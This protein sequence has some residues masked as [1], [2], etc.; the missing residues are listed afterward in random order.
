MPQKTNLNINPYYDDFDADKN[1]Y[2]VL[3]KPGFPVQARELTTLQSIFQNQIE[4]FGSHIF[5]E[6]SMVIPGSISYDSSYYSVKINSTHLGLDVTLYLDKLINKRIQGQNSGVT[7]EIK[8]YSLPPNDG[9]ED[10]TLYVK[11]ISTG[12]DFQTGIFEDGEVLITLDNIVYGNT[13]IATGET[14][15]SLVDVNATATGSAVNLTSGV[16]FLRG[17]FIDV[18]D[19]TLVLDPYSNAP[20]YRVGL[21]ISEEIIT[22]DDDSSLNDNARGFSNF[23]A[24]GAD[25]LKISTRLSKKLLTDFDDKSFV[26]LLRVDLGEIKKLQDKSVYS[27][28]K[29][30]FAQR[31]YDESGD[32]TVSP[33]DVDILNSL[34]DNLGNNGVYQETQKTDQGATP[35]DDLMIVRV[36]P[37]KAYVRG[38]DISLPGNTNI[39]VPKPRDT[40]EVPTALIPFELGSR[41]TVNNVRGTP[42]VGLNT[43]GNKVTLF[44]TRKSS[45]GVGETTVG[46]ARVYSFGLTDS[47]YNDASTK[48][49]LYLFDVQTYTRL[50]LNEVLTTSEAPKGSFIKGLSSGASGFTVADAATSTNITLSNTS[51]TFIRGEQ[52]SIN[53]TQIVSRS[54]KDITA[55]SINDIKSVYQTPQALNNALKT[56]FSADCVLY[57]KLAPDF[58]VTDAISIGGASGICTSAGKSFLGISTNSIVTYQKPDLTIPTYN[59]VVSVSPSGNSMTLGAVPSITNILDGTLPTTQINGIKFSLGVPNIK[60]S[61]NGAFY[62]PL[63]FKDVSSVNLSNA[64]LVVSTQ[65]TEQTTDSNGTMTIIT[66]NTGISSAF[67]EPFDPEKYSIFYS[68]GTIEDLTSDQLTISN[69][70]ARL[71]ITGLR[72]N[73]SGANSITVNVTLRKYNV[74]N[75]SK[76]YT[77]SQQLSVNK[78][79]SGIQTSITGL[80]SSQ[81]YGLRVEDQEISLNVPDV[82]KVIAIYESLNTSAPVLDKM[83]F[84]AGLSLDTQSVV[85]E[86]LI[87]KTSRAIGQI[88]NRIAGG[89]TIEHVTLSKNQFI[90]G[91][92]ILFEE[93]RISSTLLDYQPGSYLNIT[94]NY[95]LDKNQKIQYYDYSKIVRIPSAPA[96]T[97]QLLVIFD[98][99]KVPDADA[100]D[101][102]TVNS[103]DNERFLSDIPNLSNGV[104]A[105]DT[106]DF[107][108]RVPEFTSTNRSPF[109]FEDKGFSLYTSKAIITPNEGSLISYSHYLPRRDKVVLNKLGELSVI[110]GIS[111]LNPSTPVNVEDAMDIATI[112]LPAYLYSPDDAKI[113]FVDNRRYTMRDIGKLED[114]IENLEITTSLSLLELN[115]KTLQ[116][117]DADGLGRFKTGFFADDFKDDKFIDLEDPD[118]SCAVNTSEQTLI[119]KVD[120][121]SLGLQL[122]LDP[123]INTDTADF[124]ENLTLLD[125]NVQKTGDLITLK[126][127]QKEWIK[128]AFASRVENVN[129]FNI[130]EYSGAV[131]LNPNTDNWVR[132]IYIAKNRTVIAGGREFTYVED[133]KVSSEPDPFMR[134]RNVEFSAGGLRPLTRHYHFL[135]SITDLSIIPKLVEIEMKSG[136]F[137][138]GETISGISAIVK[139]FE[140]LKCRLAQPN[141][142]SGPYNSPTKTY[143]I[144][145]YNSSET[146]P[147]A[148]SKSSTVLNVD[149]KSLVSESLTK[150]GGAIAQGTK[151]VG[152]TSKAVAIVKDVRLITDNFGDVI[153]SFFIEDP[154]SDPAPTLKVKSGSRT[155]KLNQNSAN[156]S[157][158]PGDA[159]SISDAEGVYT[160]NGII[161]TQTTSYVTVQNPPPPPPRRGKDP[162]AQSFTVDETGAFLTSVDLFFAEK[163]PNEKLYVELR[164]V[165]LGTPTNQLLQDFSRV[166][167]EPSEIVTSTDASKPTNVKFPSPVYLQKD[168]EYAIVL[169]APTS[170]KYKVWIAK[171]GEKTVGTENLPN[172]ESVVVTKQYGK[173]SL[174]KSQNG[175]IWT[176]SQ[177]EDMKLTLYKA[178]FTS[179]DGSVYFYNPPL[180]ADSIPKENGIPILQSNPLKG[181]PR[182]LIVGVNTTTSMVNDLVVGKKVSHG[183]VSSPGSYGYIE[184][185]G[186]P[187]SVTGGTSTGVSIAN[188]GIGYTTTSTTYNNVSLYAIT[189]NGSGATANITCANGG[190]T[191][192]AIA[193]T[194]NG[195]A[196]GDILGITTS[197]V[198]KGTKARISVRTVQGTDTLYLSNVQGEQFTLN[199]NLLVY[200]ETTVTLPSPTTT[201]RSSAVLST[202]YAGNV[203]EVNQFNHGMHA[204]NNVVKIVGCE[205]DTSP[206]KLTADLPASATQIS[207]AS[208]LGFDTFEGISTSKGYLRV[209]TEII[210]YGSVNTGNTLGITTRGVDG[211]TIQSHVVGDI[212]RKYE[213]N[214][215]SLTKINTNFNMANNQALNVFKTTDKYYLEFTRSSTRNSGSSMLN[216]G[217]EKLFGGNTTSASQNYQYTG[218]LPQFA[219]ITPGKNTTISAR[220]RSVSGTSASGQEVSFE[221][222]GYED[223]QINQTTFLSSVRMVCSEVNE[224]QHLSSLPKNK[225]LT[226]KV[227][228]QSDDPNLSPVLDVKNAM[229][230]LSRNKINQPIADYIVDGRSNELTGDPHGSVYISK[231]ID[232]KQSAT[233]LKV[234]VAANRQ[235]ESDFRVLYRLF[236]SDSSE[237]T[238]SY[239]LFP[240]YKNLLDTNNDGFGDR[241]VDFSENSGLPDAYVKPNTKDQFSEYQFTADN[242]D[243]FNGF[244]IKIVMNSTDETKPI[245]LRDLRVIALA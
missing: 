49:D 66:A 149:I 167:L 43:S 119:S 107:R 154:N 223:V 151:L 86:R 1:F 168:I 102:F 225:S 175:T 40:R 218:I 207:L 21:F 70:G 220:L 235:E 53:G 180:R 54:I 18:Q 241:L 193:N 178:K 47:T 17:A 146:L 226:L 245:T 126:Y 115:T 69:G 72:A 236:K 117:Q 5:K 127:E 134:S 25:R 15:A 24:P 79:I 172:S 58:T 186:G 160:A 45:T 35:S 112:D 64:N 75:K 120:F 169:L 68:D 188:T 63:T 185:V 62:S 244:I 110:R 41:L 98:Y 173:G 227:R 179:T 162:L 184:R 97:R 92:D 153:G 73:Q 13:A 20:S 203:F 237:I 143:G 213:A 181:L 212:C 228:M 109:A 192:V 82:V 59:R 23:A 208:T 141:H 81:Y 164:T 130:V 239:V 36:S 96:P 243:P 144:N 16:Y 199:D 83:S 215:V 177:Y 158:L 90:E 230:I 204:A 163:D 78:S 232:L 195:Y 145:P 50:V 138:V 152:E 200:N 150:Y 93:S 197:Q 11:Y 52:I 219:T 4:S 84:A 140:V 216:F 85:G 56:T 95:T 89:T 76:I 3:F 27:I 106:L 217:T 214:Q 123:N 156:A 161:Q 240:G 128:Q 196:V 29:D 6:G 166:V 142:K 104:R 125:S 7:A 74:L 221:D 121:W 91:E 113:T 136:V 190:I 37:G 67:F 39:D 135:D 222:K 32:Y 129:P 46:E 55:Y 94:N 116:V 234:I 88:V 171:M 10:I 206:I 242:L 194:G 132:N 100:G 31:T 61:G 44:S 65:L 201:I 99:Y 211:S 133:V 182:K 57:P 34:N 71:D 210:E 103:Y 202:L 22:S 114:R 189:G 80:S 30:Y 26:E 224:V 28:I 77:R 12:S 157:P 42:L 174:F 51:G 229:V 187:I 155:F 209:G 111:S 87:G 122:A 198:Q 8:N 60:D 48:W 148:Y 238:Q 231:R 19:S 101:I 108:P 191:A 183:T 159:A 147:T 33:F 139:D 2:R 38:F 131:I 105:S 137:E 14:F 118:T 170:D 124:D 205:P 9:V 165:E 176:A 233:S